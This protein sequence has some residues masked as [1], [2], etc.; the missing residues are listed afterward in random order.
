[1][2][3][4]RASARR[5]LSGGGRSSGRSVLID[6]GVAFSIRSSSDDPPTTSSISAIWGSPGP[7]WRRTK[8]PRI[9]NAASGTLFCSMI[10][11]GM[12]GCSAQALD[13]RAIGVCIHELVDLRRG[14]EAD[15][16]EPAVALGAAVDLGGI[17]GERAVDLDH[18][19]AHRRID[20]ARRLDA[21][22]HGH[23]LGLADLPADLGQF[24]E[25]DVAELVLRVFADADRGGIAVH[26]DPLVLPGV[27]GIGHDE[28]LRQ[29][30]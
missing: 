28:A 19:S 2:A 26:A 25:D 6:A 4:S 24:D 22:D 17:V 23:R 8:S 18:L 1:M 3:R 13:E 20:V 16:A 21:L 27:T 29:R 11:S 12:V 5:S 7:M 9:S 10:S 14:A 15:P 30:L